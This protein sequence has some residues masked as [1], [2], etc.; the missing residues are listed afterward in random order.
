MIKTK[1]QEALLTVC[2]R[3]WFWLQGQNWKWL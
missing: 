2:D 3:Y 1:L